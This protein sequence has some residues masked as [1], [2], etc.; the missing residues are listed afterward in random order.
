MHLRLL[1]L[2]VIQQP[3]LLLK[4]GV[5]KLGS[6]AATLEWVWDPLVESVEAA[7]CPECRHPTFEFGITRQGRLTCP[8]CTKAASAP[9][10]AAKS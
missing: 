7:D 10:R 2:L 1:N 4:A 3:K 6:I 9:N 5:A 8:A